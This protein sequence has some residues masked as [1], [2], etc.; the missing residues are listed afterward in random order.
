MKNCKVKNCDHK[1]YAKGYCEKHY[2]QISRTGSIRKKSQSGFNDIIIEGPI[3]KIDLYDKLG[4]KSGT[5]IIDV[6]DYNKVKDHRW[7]ISQGYVVTGRRKAKMRLHHLIIGYPP[8][9]K[10]VD[11]KNRT[12]LDNRRCN[13]RFA[14]TAQNRCNTHGRGVGTSQFK[15]VSW[16]AQRNKWI[17]AIGNK[18]KR[19]WIG[20]FSSE[21]DAARAYDIMAKKLH[22]EFACLNF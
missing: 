10:E 21:R 11:H 6:T 16:A 9:G 19:Y 8:A 5:A 1:Y 18:G 13:L 7:G 4:N 14:T 22:G 15:G 20:Y 17:S 3:C 2:Q 12:K